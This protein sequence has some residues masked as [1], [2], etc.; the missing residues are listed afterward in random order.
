[1]A[2]KK[3]EKRDGSIVDFNK[4]KI[5]NAILKA[6]KSVDMVDEKEASNVTT[7]VVKEVNKAN[8]SIPGVEDI[9][10]IV[11]E[12]LMKKLPKV[13]KEYITYRNQRNIIRNRKSATMI[14]IKKILNCSNVQ[15][16][17][18]NIDEYSFGGRKNESANL[19][20]K[21]IALNDLIDPEIT[22]AYNEGR[23]Y[24][25]DLSE[26][27][28]GEHNCLFADIPRLLANGFEARNGDVRPA[29]C[30]STACQLL[31]VIFQIQSQCQ[32][33]GVADNAIDRHLAPYVRKSFIKHY[34]NGLHWFGNPGDWDTFT[35]N[36][37]FNI[38]TASISAEWN[39]FKAFNRMAYMFAMESLEKEGLQSTQ[40]LYHN[41]NTLESRAGSQV[42]F[43]SIN[44]GLDTSFE[45]R[46][47]TEWC[48]KASIDGIGKNHS[49]SI[50]PI[51]IFVNKKEVNDRV[52]TPNYDLKKLAIK[53]LTKRIYPN[54]ANGDWISN[55]ADLHPIKFINKEYEAA[56]SNDEVMIRTDFDYM[57]KLK[58]KT[59]E[60][61]TTLG[62][63]I[64]KVIACNNTDVIANHKEVTIKFVNH[65]D[66][67]LI[68][69]SNCSNNDYNRR[70]NDHYTRLYY[71]HYTINDFGNIEK[72][73]ITTE[74][75]GYDIHKKHISDYSDLA[76]I[77]VSYPNPKWNYNPDTE[78]ATM[79][80]RTLI[81]NDVN[82]MG[83][84]KL[85]RGNVT[86]VTIN[87]P[88]IGI[89]HGICLGERDTP[90]EEGFFKELNHML[91]LATKELLD[92]YKYICSQSIKAG[93][94]MYNNGT[95]ADS[96]KALFFGVK[97]SMK[98]GSQA[99][100]YIG[101][102][103][104]CYAMYGKYFHQD[105]KVMEFAKKVIKTIYERAK[106]N[107][108]KYHLNFS[109]YSSPSESTCYTLATK[110]QK[111]FGKIKNVCDRDYLTNSC[112]VPVYENISIRDKIDT[113]SNFTWMCTGG[114][115][116]YIELNS[117]V[118]NN[119]RAVEKIINYAMNNERIP[120]FAINFPID[121]CNHC[122]F[123]GEIEEHCPACGSD[124]IKRLRRVTGYITTDYRK[125]NKGKISETNDRVKH[126]L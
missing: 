32:F 7:Q 33:G 93:S 75:A 54:F 67:F 76:V 19:I 53:S 78:M 82:G 34:K 111:K 112:H 12:K 23:L 87:L 55:K 48:L 36:H 79:G 40:A 39:I 113:E 42:P 2:I 14:N 73:Y 70:E 15:N 92:R 47:V 69:D 25:H 98:H 126:T 117:G 52:Y 57:D 30:F 77:H 101:L 63:F 120:Y 61:H 104:A 16:S 31:A 28:I 4:D 83:Y 37:E 21:E 44:F 29:S 1:M 18:A 46:K 20:Q 72:I 8:K 84:N 81:G 6:M 45:G 58:K 85:G 116:T 109:A 103:N 5:T 3:I 118:I 94:F 122:G 50:F 10:D 110:L 105:K 121:T 124:D 119:P 74:S 100:G 13:A 9:Q 89:E 49:T 88:Y 97:E 27:T 66:R 68:K 114:C 24:I 41:L 108:E 65:K 106:E 90:D 91:D 123:S 35:A 26:Y 51:S 56:D 71:I 99:L 38:E 64:K 95:I 11:E 96:D 115:I 86:P 60:E 62:A 22:E 43:T 80:C 125:F 107:T 17:N 102:A 59:V